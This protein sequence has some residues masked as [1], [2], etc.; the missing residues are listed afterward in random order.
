[1]SPPKN[2]P[3]K[4][5]RPRNADR[6]GGPPPS[7]A[8]VP[9]SVQVDP[10]QLAREA[11]DHDRTTGGAG[12]A[13]APAPVPALSPAVA[14][15]RLGMLHKALFDF[16]AELAHSS[17]RL[18][19]SDV[20]ELGETGDLVFRNTFGEAYEAKLP[21]A[22]YVGTCLAIGAAIWATRGTMKQPDPSL[23]VAAPEEK[24]DR[25]RAAVAREGFGDPL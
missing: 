2:R 13:P 14:K 10:A 6:A 17:Y 5:G 24:P 3:S 15:K 1:M 21:L 8:A 16:S 4:R 11:D 18:T 23:P 19:D 22:A 7:S 25:T 9:P 12:A 20:D